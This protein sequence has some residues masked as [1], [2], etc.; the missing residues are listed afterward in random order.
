MLIYFRVSFDC[1]TTPSNSMPMLYLVHEITTFQYKPEVFNLIMISKL[2]K[3]T[4]FSL[5]NEIKTVLSHWSKREKCFKR[6]Y[7][8]Q[9]CRVG[10]PSYDIV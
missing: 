1:A 9:N 6:D 2:F 3:I 5:V 7:D 10:H 4:I 8:G